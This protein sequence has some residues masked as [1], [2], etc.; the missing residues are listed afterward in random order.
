MIV[1]LL[2][3]IFDCQVK[4]LL[5]F[6]ILNFTSNLVLSNYLFLIFFTREQRRAKMRV[7]GEMVVGGT[8]GDMYDVLMKWRIMFLY[9]I[10]FV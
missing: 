5:K 7:K 8:S 3:L 4:L 1:F 6:I 10:L 9:F 2:Q